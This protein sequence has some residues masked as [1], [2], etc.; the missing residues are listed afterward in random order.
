[1]RDVGRLVTR[2]PALMSSSLERKLRPTV[3]FLLTQGLVPADFDRMLT[4]HPALFTHRRARG[5]PQCD[6]HCSKRSPAE[7]AALL[8]ATARS[9]ND[10][11]IPVVDFLSDLGVKDVA[12]VLRAMPQARAP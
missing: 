6:R 10:K 9:L 7:C 1:M 12:R 4:K 8:H 2:S 5:A 11:I 3:A